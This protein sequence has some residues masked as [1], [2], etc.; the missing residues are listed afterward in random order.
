MPRPS[1]V[2]LVLSQQ[3]D[4]VD[5]VHDALRQH[6][7][8]VSVDEE[9]LAQSPACGIAVALNQGHHPFRKGDPRFEDVSDFV[10]VHLE[11]EEIQRIIFQ[12]RVF[13][14]WG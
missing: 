6:E 13:V 14:Q 9:L 2:D 1:A 3:A 7:P 4:R 12:L 10:S 8:V 11:Q 5:D